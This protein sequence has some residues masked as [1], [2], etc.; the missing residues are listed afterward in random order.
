MSRGLLMGYPFKINDSVTLGTDNHAMTEIYFGDWNQFMIGETLGLEIA[1]S[2]EASYMDGA[3]LVSAFAN[4][5][6]VMR[7]LLR[8]DFG[9]RYGSAFVVKQQVWIK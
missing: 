4:D 1:V 9:V 8:E 6:T 7:A 5:Q 2:Q 3:T